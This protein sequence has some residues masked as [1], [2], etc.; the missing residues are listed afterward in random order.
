LFFA[1]LIHPCCNQIKSQGENENKE[2]KTKIKRKNGR[3]ERKIWQKTVFV[4]RKNDG[5]I[6][7]IPIYR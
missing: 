6:A 3:L 2:G 7:K 5:P 1:I 4:F